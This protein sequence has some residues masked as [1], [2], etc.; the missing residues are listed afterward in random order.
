MRHRPLRTSRPTPTKGFA[1]ARHESPR[2]RSAYDVEGHAGDV[3][4]HHRR[5]CHSRANGVCARRSR[6]VSR[7]QSQ[8]HCIQAQRLWRI[9]AHG[10]L[11]S[12]CESLCL[13]SCVESRS[14]SWTGSALHA[15][16][17]SWHNAECV[18]FVVRCVQGARMRQGCSSPGISR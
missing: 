4:A 14:T 8:T 11:Q 1:P 13:M 18:A 2:E 6:R 17:V 10:H 3:L 5:R 16:A 9:R 7:C 12:E 15:A